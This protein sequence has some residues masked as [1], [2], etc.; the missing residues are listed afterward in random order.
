MLPAGL[1]GAIFLLLAGI[2]HVAKKGKNAEE[3]LAT[4]TDELVGVVVVVVGFY[5]LVPALIG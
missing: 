5:M 4:W 2:L 1:G 3:A